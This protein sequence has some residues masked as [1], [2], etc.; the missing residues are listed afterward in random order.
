[1]VWM[2]KSSKDGGCRPQFF[3]NKQDI[4]NDNLKEP[5]KSTLLH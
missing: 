3:T 5:N 4:D 2:P 1:M